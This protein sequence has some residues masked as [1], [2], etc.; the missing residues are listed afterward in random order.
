MTLTRR[1]L[2]LLA[3]L[4]GMSL[5]VASC[6]GDDSDSDD[7]GAAPVDRSEGE[8]APGGEF[9][10]LGT[11]VGDPLE[12][13]DPALNV[14]IDGFQIVN[15]V[16]DG[17]TEIDFSD[18]EE[19]ELKG[20]VAESWTVNDDAT[21]F[22]FTIKEGLEFSNGEPVLPSSFV[23]AWERA[24]DPE[25]AGQY[26]YLFNFLEGG[27]A[28]LDG[29]AETI[30]GVTADD[31]AMT[32]TTKLA[33]PYA[34]WPT[35][36]GFQLFYPM[37][38]AVEELGDQNEWENGLMIGNGPYMLESP[39]TTEEIVLVKNEAYAGDHNGERWEDRL[40]KITFRTSA[41]PDTAYNAFE[42]GEG[43]NAIV[44]P[45]R[46]G[47]ASND[48]PNAIRP[49]LGT[50]YFEVKWDHPVLG[51]PDN[52]KLREAIMLAIDR[53]EIGEAVYDGTN[54]VATSLIPPGIPGHTADICEFCKHD[55]AAAEAAFAEWTAAGNSL[56]EPIKI[57]LNADAG[58]EP[59]VQIIV[60]NLRE[61]G[62]DAVADP[63]P[64]ETYFTQLGE[65]ACVIC[66]SGWYAD[67]PTA[68]NFTYDLFHSDA[69][70]GNNHGYYSNAE[71]DR[72]ID[73]AKRTTDEDEAADLYSQAEDILLNQD[74]GVIP[75]L[76]Y[77]LDY[78]YG[79][80]L[81]RFPV[82]P[83]GLIQWEQ[84]AFKA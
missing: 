69:I 31:E 77:S 16:Y 26:S 5:F 61:V 13:I 54:E 46:W 72:L 37:P 35:V 9:V 24:S 3:I 82:S 68:D 59:V 21:E 20:L 8:A 40:E 30:S 43:D 63:M 67:Y 6:G 18:P 66:R 47:D 27:E 2:Q 23:V 74:I 34:N 22:V 79:D 39:R 50:R 10:D 4:L 83:L 11:V 57:N 80:D 12:H 56:T 1:S 62:I 25:F 29:A 38:T 70:G 7:E 78:V 55:P 19:P 71:F 48:H 45:G 28:K 58:H 51:G 44:P 36:A 49:A 65:G 17:L 14:T 53:E 76:Y 81:A 52:V 73:E 42:A 75:Y 32:L 33:A 60:D 15:A 41:D 84:V 64:T